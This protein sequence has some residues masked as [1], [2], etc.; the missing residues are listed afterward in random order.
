MSRGRGNEDAT[1]PKAPRALPGRLRY[2]LG[3]SSGKV[4]GALTGVVVLATGSFELYQKVFP[5]PPVEQAASFA[6]SDLEQYGP[7]TTFQEYLELVGSPKLSPP[8]TKEQ[9][10]ARGMYITVPATLVGLKNVET[11][12]VY[13]LYH[14]NNM[15]PLKNW[16]Y[17]QEN[18]VK[19][20]RDKFTTLLSMW[21]QMPGEPGTY[22]AVVSLVS[23]DGESLA[24]VRTKPFTVS[25]SSTPVM[26]GVLVSIAPV[27]RVPLKPGSR[28]DK[29]KLNVVKFSISVTNKLDVKLAQVR[30][31]DQ[32]FP[33]CNRTFATLA[34]GQEVHYSCIEASAKCR[35]ANHLVVRSQ[36]ISIAE[37]RPN[38]SHNH[39]VF[40]WPKQTAVDRAAGGMDL[41]CYE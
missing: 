9:R 28:S 25:D 40:G 17:E 13:S 36:S 15:A 14:A 5:P 39:V 3:S 29:V 32:E 41:A 4:V 31:T 24:S 37:Q 21:I 16:I 20:G 33:Q 26:A 12:V 27:A 18:Q 30:V 22:V 23:R 38:T 11:S 35:F 2:W 8:P 19:A 34:P 10:N 1:A 6:S 7:P